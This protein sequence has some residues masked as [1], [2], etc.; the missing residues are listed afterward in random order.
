MIM[1][2]PLPPDLCRRCGRGLITRAATTRHGDRFYRCPSCGARYRRESRDGPWHD[3]S[4]QVYD[5]MYS[6]L[7]QDGLGERARRPIDES[8]YWTETVSSL[9]R[10]KRIRQ[11]TRS[12]GRGAWKKLASAGPSISTAAQVRKADRGLWDSELDG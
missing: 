12:G 5:V 7:E 2:S 3:A 8:R 11:I 10:N 9:L 4:A 1:D 6:R